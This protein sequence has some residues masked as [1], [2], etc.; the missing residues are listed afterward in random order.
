MKGST[1][2]ATWTDGHSLFYALFNKSGGQLIAGKVTRKAQRKSSCPERW[3]PAGFVVPARLTVKQE[4]YCKRALGISR[5]CYNLAVNTHRHIRVNRLEWAS[6]Q[7]IYKAFNACKR[8]DYPFVT[9]V[10]S[11]VAEGAFMDFGRAMANW[12]NKSIKAGVPVIKRKKAAGMGSARLASGVASIKYNGKRRVQ[13]PGIGSV[14]LAC[15]LPKGIYHEAHI[16]RRNGRWYLS[17]KYWQAPSPVPVDDV[18]GIGGVDTGINPLGA[19]S[20]GEKYANPKAVY[21]VDKRLRRWQRAQERR[22]KGSRGWWEAQRKIDNCHRRIRG[23]GGNARHQMTSRVIGKYRVLGIEDLNVKGMMQGL[24]PRAQGDAGMGEIKRQL[25]YKGERRHTEIVMAD[26]WYPSSKRCSA[27]G[28]VNAKLKR[29]PVWECPCCGVRHDRNVNAALNLKELA[30]N[31]TT[32][33]LGEGRMLRDGLALACLERVGGT[34]P[35][36]RESGGTENSTG[37][38][39]NGVD[40]RQS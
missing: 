25:I 27:C 22:T 29:E 35:E 7:D 23:I 38:F 20:D 2:L 3:V 36:S 32:M 40:A 6:W 30:I 33:P 4:R 9:E 28:L 15:T 19:D 18:R 37:G 21:Q 16:R 12:R 1:K 17:L 14:K 5:F 11:R 26:R 24:T 13:L 8:E 31:R 34:G 39:N 10:H